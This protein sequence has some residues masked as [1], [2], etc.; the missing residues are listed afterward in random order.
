M[1]S[2]TRI[3]E[4]IKGYTPLA[5]GK[6]TR[7]I[8]HFGDPAM[9]SNG[10]VLFLGSMPETL[11]AAGE[12]I[13][14]DGKPQVQ[15]LEKAGIA[16]LFESTMSM[17]TLNATPL[18]MGEYKPGKKTLQIVTFLDETDRELLF[19]G[20]YVASMIALCGVDKAPDQYVW[21]VRKDNQPLLS[22]FHVT[23]KMYEPLSMLIGL[24]KKADL[25]S[26]ILWEEPTPEET[27]E[28]ETAIVVAE[29]TPEPDPEPEPTPEPEPEPR[30]IRWKAQKGPKAQLFDDGWE[31]GLSS[32]NIA[33]AKA[34]HLPS[35]TTTGGILTAKEGLIE[36]PSATKNG[37]WPDIDAGVD[38]ALAMG[39]SEDQPFLGIWYSANRDEL[40][41]IDYANADRMAHEEGGFGVM[42]ITPKRAYLVPGRHEDVF[43]KEIRYADRK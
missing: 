30:V 15:L 36:C 19:D 2:V 33:F 14:K 24:Q 4:R 43:A 40:E 16:E 42:V 18:K 39:E 28:P 34:I 26:C 41:E 13:A 12:K 32:F 23:G 3:K 10:H 6:K 37:Y 38:R 20:R 17:S 1:L 25:E 11:K 9:W 5:I 29:P 31:I 27:P 21:K 35:D 7:R 22:L 8:V